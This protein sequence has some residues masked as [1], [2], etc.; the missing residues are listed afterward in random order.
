MV[1][2]NR[3][4]KEQKRYVHSL[5]AEA[6]I[7][8]RPPGLEVCHGDG[9]PTNNRPENLRYGSHGSNLLDRVRHGTHHQ[10]NKTHCPRRH[11]LTAPNLV[12]SKAATGH[13]NCLACARASANAAKHKARGE[14]GFDFVAAADD[15]FA[16]IMS[17]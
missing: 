4:G 11:L 10:S 12:A 8:P 13:R 1:G 3:E 14:T 2:L 5:V 16:R 17:A 9:I 15:H 7:G 6:F